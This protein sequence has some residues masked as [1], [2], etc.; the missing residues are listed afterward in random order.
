MLALESHQQQ[1]QQQ[2]I[3]IEDLLSVPVTMSQQQFHHHLHHQ[4]EG[5]STSTPP[6]YHQPSHQDWSHHQDFLSSSSPPNFNS[7]TSLPDFGSPLSLQDLMVAS[8][9]NLQQGWS[10]PDQAFSSPTHDYSSSPDEC[11]SPLHNNAPNSPSPFDAN[12]ASPPPPPTNN[13]GLLKCP[14]CEDGVSGEHIYYGG[15]SCHS[16]RVFFRRAVHSGMDAPGALVCKRS[17]PGTLCEI[18]SKSRR[19]CKACRLYRCINVA[20]LDRTQVTRGSGGVLVKYKNAA[21]VGNFNY[22][23]EP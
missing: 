18:R 23:K 1:Q 4:A 17:G 2:H 6:E 10:S 20:G 16:C 21:V 5:C 14:V 9:M 3:N 7:P 22:C 8:P 11:G 15:R 13:G 12:A 19:A